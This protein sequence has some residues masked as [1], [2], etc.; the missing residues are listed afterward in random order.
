MNCWN[1]FYKVKKNMQYC[2]HCGVKLNQDDADIARINTQNE[3]NTSTL[4][5]ISGEQKQEFKKKLPVLTIGL[6]MLSV[7]LAGLLFLS[8]TGKLSPA[9]QEILGHIA[10]KTEI[11]AT[12]EIIRTKTAT[13]T[14][15]IIATEIIIPEEKISSFFTEANKSLVSPEEVMTRFAECLK[16]N[17]FESAL[18]LFSINHRAENYDFNGYIDRIQSFI[19]Y[20][21]MA[22]AE[23]DPYLVLNKAYLLRSAAVQIKGFTYS[24]LFPEQ[25]SAGTILLDTIEKQNWDILTLLDPSR[26]SALRLIRTDLVAPETQLSER[27]QNN[28]KAMGN[29]FGFQDQKEY[30]ALYEFEG[31]YYC[32]SFTIG[33][34]EEG[35][36]INYLNSNLA[37]ADVLNNILEITE[38]EYLEMIQ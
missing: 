19:P 21:S 1:C 25:I 7:V 35:W 30:Y 6:T 16:N 32:G 17:D 8:L 20:S 12:H 2:P 33:E 13:E 11:S 15:T 18:N 9:A 29:I 4:K 3:K 31:K 10:E 34:Y 38:D 26:L 23:Y 22:P 37:G 5:T 36:Q 14:A 27:M 24:L 28:V